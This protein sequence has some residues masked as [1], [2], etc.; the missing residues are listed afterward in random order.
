MNLEGTSLRVGIVL[1]VLLVALPGIFLV[2]NTCRAEAESTTINIDGSSTVYPIAEAVLEEFKAR[3]P[4]VRIAL[5]KSGTGGGFKRFVN[6]ETPISNASRPIKEKEI[7]KCRENGIDFVELEIALD[8]ITFVVGKHNDWCDELSVE[9]L[10][11]IFLDRVPDQV[12]RWSDLD[13]AW[14]AD[15][16]QLF[17]P[18]ADS[19]TFD[20]FREVMEKTMGRKVSVRNDLVTPSEDDNTL[21]HGVGQDQQG[22][23]LG[24]F[25]CAYYFENTDTLRALGINGVKPTHDTIQSDRY[26][27][28]SRPLFLYVN[29]DKLGEPY[30]KEWLEF[31]L[32]SMEKRGRDE[33]AAERVGY[34]RLSDERL[35]TARRRF[36][37]ALARHA[38]RKGR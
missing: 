17:I 22:R 37:Q 7:Q 6:G 18:G 33:N 23:G 19:G 20:Y 29:V 15:E 2:L 21:V 9:Q 25:G 14:P 8:G 11:R 16:L 30:V 28:F 10:T 4:H 26:R 36:E 24:F 13:P 27:P 34:V 3:Y 38:E 1:L 35:A 32:E 5:S 12:N 31:F